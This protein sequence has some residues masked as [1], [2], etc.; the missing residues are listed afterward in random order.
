MRPS[1]PSLLTNK[2]TNSLFTPTFNELNQKYH[3]NYKIIRDDSELPEF[4]QQLSA[5]SRIALDIETTG[6]NPLLDQLV[7]ISLSTAHSSGFYLPVNHKTGE[8][9][10]SLESVFPYLSE[11]F[12][13]K[14]ITASSA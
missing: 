14:R 10:L 5:P 7:G 4:F 3:T 8:K 2:C 13:D 9:Q 12:A 11:I 1:L 6:L